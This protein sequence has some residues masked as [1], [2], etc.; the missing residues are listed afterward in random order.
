MNTRLP[1][2]LC[3][4]FALAACETGGGGHLVR[5]IDARRMHEQLR[6]SG[7]D[8][9]YRLRCSFRNETGYNGST[10]LDIRD[11]RVID[12]ATS[13][14]VPEAGGSC[15]IE[16]PGFRLTRFQPSIELR[17]PDGCTARIWTQGR[18]MTVSYTHCEA[19]CS[20]PQVFRK[21][22]PVLIDMPS[23]HCD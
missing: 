3:L 14:N 7:D 9:N 4:C 12:L 16:G 10:R 20:N 11:N 2:L 15:R 13:I 17:H 19:R 22:W 1:C 8:L 18:Q 21:T 5:Q 23:G 6:S